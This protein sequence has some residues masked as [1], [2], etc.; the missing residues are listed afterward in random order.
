MTAADALRSR[1]HQGR[2]GVAATIATGFITSAAVF[3]LL[4]SGTV[5]VALAVSFGIA[6]PI[7]QHFAVS[8]SAGDMAA[9][10][11]FAEL[12]WIPGVIAIASF[13]AAAIVATTAGR[14]LSVRPVT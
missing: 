12:W 11:R 9:L 5:L 8:I 4:V 14:H 7:A 13:V 3:G 1:N 6:I 10:A 2:P